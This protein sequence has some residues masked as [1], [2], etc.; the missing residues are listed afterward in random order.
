MEVKKLTY[1]ILTI[2]IAVVLVS[3]VLIPAISSSSTTTTTVEKENEGY[4]YTMTDQAGD[5]T[6]SVDTSTYA[7]LLNGDALEFF[8]ETSST[9]LAGVATPT[10]DAMFK[11]TKVSNVDVISEGADGMLN[12]TSFTLS[13]GT[14]TYSAYKDGSTKTYT[15]TFDSDKALYAVNGGN[16]AAF[17]GGASFSVNTGD[18]VYYTTSYTSIG[19]TYNVAYR[20]SIVNGVTTVDY[21]NK[22]V[23]GVVTPID[24]AATCTYDDMATTNGVTTYTNFTV[25]ITSSSGEVSD[26]YPAYIVAPRTYTE[27]I[28]TEQTGAEFTLI[29]IIPLLVLVGVMLGAV[30]LFISRR[31]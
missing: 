10:F 11:N 16:Y 1:G 13:N 27:T 12:P 31:D 20:V 17:S 14:F 5:Y 2:I 9:Y 29:N 22:I 18:T 7:T 25:T 30:G 4:L 28:T 26:F 6:Y 24:I 15:G 21:A 8:S 19:S 3:A 23:S